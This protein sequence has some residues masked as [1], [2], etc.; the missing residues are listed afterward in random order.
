[1][2]ESSGYGAGGDYGERFDRKH[3]QDRLDRQAIT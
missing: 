1:M 2:K 3:D